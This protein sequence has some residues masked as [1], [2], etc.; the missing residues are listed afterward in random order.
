M[1]L[2]VSIAVC[3]ILLFAI[4]W[5]AVADT[6]TAV[7]AAEAVRP[8]CLARRLS[9]EP[10]TERWRIAKA[11]ALERAVEAGDPGAR[12]EWIRRQ[13]A[14][15]GV[16]RDPDLALRL[17]RE[18][19][20]G[21]DRAAQY[22]LGNYHS[23]EEPIPGNDV[24]VGNYQLAAEWLGAAAGQ[25]HVEAAFELGELYHYGKLPRDT[26]EAIRWFKM[27][28]E[29]GHV[30][31]SAK[32]AS[33]LAYGGKTAAGEAIPGQ[34]E[35]AIRWYQ[36]A[37]ERGYDDAAVELAALLGGRYFVP[38][39]N[40]PADPDT[41]KKWLL[42][43]ARRGHAPSKALLAIAFD[44]TSTLRASDLPGLI[45]AANSGGSSDSA[46][47]L[48]RL[49]EEGRWVP[50]DP[51][52]AMHYY[53]RVGGVSAS[54]TNLLIAT[55]TA[56][57][58]LYASGEINPDKSGARPELPNN[59]KL[60]PSREVRLQLAELLWRGNQ[61]VPRDRALALE[62][63]L[64]SAQAGSAPAMRRIGQFWA[65]GVNGQPDPDEARRW[66]RRAEAI[67]KNAPPLAR[68]PKNTATPTP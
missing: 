2:N 47:L 32:L 53:R 30:E 19:A 9:G 5:P 13:A 51:N 26:A 46:L 55:A 48:G 21:G 34:R 41:A 60:V 45:Q 36:L 11:S 12:L 59:P 63:F 37:I 39:Q 28:A 24:L 25:G 50:K 16:P 40:Y 52:E 31:A 56:V 67:E 15:E 58:R 61:A 18:A 57:V 49:Y 62:W 66:V 17:L 27:A 6:E 4:G 35:E 33:H 42:K 54:T 22:W 68:P 14:G 44:D 7:P 23:V 20:A 1:K 64:L 65:E 38:E 43:S 3:A 10:L 29:A 8:S